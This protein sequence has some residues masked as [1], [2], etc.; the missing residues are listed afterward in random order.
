MFAF[1]SEDGAQQQTQLKRWTMLEKIGRLANQ[2]SPREKKISCFI[3]YAW[4]TEEHKQWV[5][6]LA[7]DLTA[8]G[9]TVLLDK[10][11]IDVSANLEQALEKEIRLADAVLVVGSKSYKE[12]TEWH[13]HLNAPEPV[14]SR[15]W[16]KI[17][18]NIAP[19]K[20]IPLL[21]ADEP[22]EAFPEGL[23][24]D[25]L[26]FDKLYTDFRVEADYENKLIKV[27]TTLYNL[28]APEIN[29]EIE[30][31]RKSSETPQ[32]SFEDKIKALKIQ[33]GR[34][35]EHLRNFVNPVAFFNIPSYNA[36]FVGRT[37]KLIEIE[38][39]LSD[40]QP[41]LLVSLHGLGGI[42]KSQLA[43]KYAYDYQHSYPS[44]VFWFNAE[45]EAQL[46]LEY[47]KLAIKLGIDIANLKALE[48]TEK[49][50]DTLEQKDNWLIIFDNAENQL[51]LETFLPKQGGKVIITSRYTEFAGSKIDLGAFELSE[52]I[53]YVK[54]V[55]GFDATPEVLKLIELLG[56]LPL[57]LAQACAY[58][59]LG[60][61]TAGEYLK[62]YS[63]SQVKLLEI[64]KLKGLSN[65]QVSAV[66]ITWDVTMDKISQENPKAAQL[67]NFI[68]YLNAS[69]IPYFLLEDF[70]KQEGIDEIDIDEAI[71]VLLGYS[72][73]HREEDQSYSIHHLVQ[74]VIRSKDK[75]SNHLIS[76]ETSN[77]FGIFEK[78][79]KARSYS[80]GEFLLIRSI[81][82]HAIQFLEVYPKRTCDFLSRAKIQLELAKDYIDLEKFDA[83]VKL[84]TEPLGMVNITVYNMPLYYVPMNMLREGYKKLVE[85]LKT[86]N[87]PLNL[88]ATLLEKLG[89]SYLQLA[90]MKSKYS[91]SYLD[92]IEFAISATKLSIDLKI[93]YYGTDN[94]E[95]AIGLYYVI[96]LISE[97]GRGNNLG[98]LKRIEKIGAVLRDIGRAF[99]LKNSEF[100]KFDDYANY[101][102]REFSKKALHIKQRYFRLKE[103]LYALD[104]TVVQSAREL[105]T[106]ALKMANEVNRNEATFWVING[107]IPYASNKDKME[108]LAIALKYSEEIY[109]S[110]ALHTAKIKLQ[111]FE[112]SS[113]Y[114]KSQKEYKLLFDT[115]NILDRIG[116]EQYISF[117][118]KLL[119][120]FIKNPE[121]IKHMESAELDLIFNIF[122]KYLSN[123][124]LSDLF[125]QIIT[126]TVIAGKFNDLYD[127]CRS[128]QVFLTEENLISILRILVKMNDTSLEVQIE[129]MIALKFMKKINDHDI[130]IFSN[131]LS[132]EYNCEKIL[133]A[134]KKLE[135]E[136]HPIIL[137]KH[138]KNFT[139][140][141]IKVCQIA[142]KALHDAKQINNE[143]II[144]LIQ[145]VEQKSDYDKIIFILS[146]NGYKLSDYLT[147]ESVYSKLFSC[148]FGTVLQEVAKLLLE[149]GIKVEESIRVLVMNLSSD[150]KDIR[151]EAAKIL[152]KQ[153]EMKMLMEQGRIREYEEALVNKLSFYSSDLR[154]EASKVLIERG[155]IKEYEEALVKNLASD[156]ENIRQEVA[157]LMLGRNKE[158]EKATEAL[159]KNLTSDN[160]NIR[161]EAAKLMLERN[162]EIGKAVEI[163]A[164]V[165]NLAS[166]NEGSRQE[167]A[168]ILIERGK[169]KEYEEALVK[170]L[171]SDRWNI[172]QEA[173][174]I[175]IE[176]GKI[177]EYEEA[178]VKNLAS[179]NEDIRQE[180]AKLMLERNKEVERAIE[181]L[182]KNLASDDEYIRRKASKILIK[183]GKIEE[184]EEALVKNLASD[185][186]D[187]RQE[188]AKLM[189]ERNK[190]VE[191]AIEALVKNVVSNNEDTRQEAT[192]ILAKQGRTK[193]CEEA[194][195]KNL[196]S[197]SHEFHQDLSGILLWRGRI[198]EYEEALVKNLSSNSDGL[199]EKSAKI[200]LDRNVEQ[201]KAIEALVKNLASDR[202]NIRQ[203]AAKTLIERGKIKE[204]EEALVKNLASDNENI[205]QE[206][207][208][209]MLE[210]NK[211]F[212]RAIE[213]LVK[214]LASGNAY[215]RQEAAKLMLERNKEVE[216][217]IEALVNNLA[218]DD[219]YTR[220]EAA[221]LMLEQDRVKEYEEALVRN[222]AS[223]SQCIRQEAAKILIKRGRLKEYK[224]VLAKNLS[225]DRYELRHEASDELLKF[226]QQEKL[227]HIF[228]KNLSSDEEYIKD[229][230][231][232]LLLKRN[233]K[234]RES[235]SSFFSVSKTEHDDNRWYTRDEINFL[236]KNNI[237]ESGQRIV[238]ST[239][240]LDTDWNVGNTLMDN[241]IQ[242]NQQKLQ[243]VVNEQA[244]KERMIIPLNLGTTEGQGIH[245]ALLY[246]ICNA[247]DASK[248][249]HAIFLDPYGRSM[250]ETIEGN[251]KEIFPDIEI[252]NPQVPFQNDSYN[253]GP[254]IVEIANYLI[255]H[256][257]ELPLEDFDISAARLRHQK[258]LEE[259]QA[260]QKEER[261]SLGK[262]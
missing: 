186:E 46:S 113:S 93:D 261:V 80:P 172:R 194:L 60:Q 146:S 30:V 24:G 175:L 202:W 158:I 225:S 195:V 165:K 236:L 193:E 74:E 90:R 43:V 233:G 232:N 25:K 230:A 124:N 92:L 152:I 132:N 144:K 250:P 47:Q 123:K 237:N 251:L 23:L 76:Q 204:Y 200:L 203:E 240:M 257:E 179:D 129:V 45:N 242:F 212:E 63:K 145:G 100:D 70:L 54:K 28:D 110:D 12:K 211:E 10:F 254:W 71:N 78:H 163:E 154:Q 79:L 215:I 135:L 103:R 20:Q 187:I 227:I 101:L 22:K 84:L 155:K 52:A 14:L 246:I 136:E 97:L 249:S 207:A 216:R 121:F 91:N 105:V 112:N 224:E 259:L 209:L 36:N 82:P 153:E 174:K 256:D 116:A 208:K 125:N 217:A 68:A 138:L 190:E 226:D 67:L 133:V 61:K 4:D 39:A 8:S 143:A 159:V 201:E 34:N 167:A 171:A 15:E 42:G 55:T 219:A 137:Q 206:V 64:N 62:F 258:I 13:E 180:V 114:N 21:L 205:R 3:S 262:K 104:E 253:C 108:L 131:G 141:S 9:I 182:V 17:K 32:N 199:R 107:L 27:L 229:E 160:E 16:R 117:I 126:W 49:V 11:T 65:P 162:K 86:R 66:A 88:A 35:V 156:N 81:I 220:Q 231:K 115:L 58:I 248:L 222:L 168:K 181:A 188:A 5:E 149:N 176:R 223:D 214:N 48:I 102:G 139:S 196:S 169:I 228:L 41:V 40:N 198:K 89:F 241:L 150:D 85:D 238:I 170:N 184:Y 255:N 130:E 134:L 177:E 128:N 122:A 99:D 161:Q 252:L 56:G 173:A 260:G 96:L 157:E 247:Q 118:S 178:L 53:E 185:N 166:N 72:M 57:A 119:N 98:S 44:G 83:A 183:R 2:K 18:N 87:F 50:R 37:E 213:A 109:G 127:M 95:T 1:W 59:R 106:Q 75:K 7:Y 31:I 234:I 19:N 210:R 111:I 221:K 94:S 77:L 245:W 142:F 164:L 235:S 140:S 6:R 38:K 191:K 148:T 192:K 243:A 218:S 189:L 197:D 73:L 33:A 151:Q 244:I 120:A 26:V 239:S 69:G 51:A 29:S 147:I